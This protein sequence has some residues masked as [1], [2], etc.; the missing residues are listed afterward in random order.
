[1]DASL[2]ER[3]D[4]LEQIE[5]LKQLKYRYC[6]AVDA[7][8]DAD[9]LAAMFTEDGVWDGAELG[10]YAGREA[11]RESFLEPN[12][13]VQ[14]MRHCVFNPIIVIAGDRARCTWYMWLPKILSDGAGKSFQGGT[15]VDQCRRVDRQWLFEYMQVR[16]RKLP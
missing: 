13:S 12:A 9:A 4:R 14:W 6:A 7:N 16:L 15:H 11:I 5:E 3:I 1:M 8:Y 2:A 10:C